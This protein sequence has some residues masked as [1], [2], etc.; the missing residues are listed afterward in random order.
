MIALCVQVLELR[1]PGKK[2]ANFGSLIEELKKADEEMKRDATQLKITL[3]I[4][5]SKT[6]N[7]LISTALFNTILSPNVP[8]HIKEGRLRALELVNSGKILTN[9]LPLIDQLVEVGQPKGE[10]DVKPVVLFNRSRSGVL[11]MLLERFNV[12]T[13]SILVNTEGWN[14]FQKVN[15]FLLFIMIIIF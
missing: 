11:T 7:G 8:D 1:S 14:S 6:S 9:L 13:A 2:G 15:I 12:D 10:A 5:F 4:F 3:S